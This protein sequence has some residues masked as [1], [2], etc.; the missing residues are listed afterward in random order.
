MEGF[1]HLV[2]VALRHAR[3][4]HFVRYILLFVQA[5]RHRAKAFLIPRFPCVERRVERVAFGA[6]RYLLLKERP[7]S[8]RN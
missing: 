7:S 4:H 2:E 3:A 8:F 5:L 1:Y 6:E